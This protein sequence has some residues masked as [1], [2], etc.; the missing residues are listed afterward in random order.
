MPKMLLLALAAAAVAL[1][2][3]AQNTTRVADS[4][5]YEYVC[6]P[7]SAVKYRKDKAENWPGEWIPA[8]PGGTCRTYTRRSSGAASLQI[9]TN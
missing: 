1:T 3:C 4:G 6:K 7:G 2:G 8:G 5:D 9:N